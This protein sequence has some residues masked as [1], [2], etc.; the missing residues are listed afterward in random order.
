M[1]GRRDFLTVGLGTLA[2]ARAWGQDRPA[3]RPVKSV[4]WIWMDGGASQ[5]DTWDPKPGHPNSG[6]LHAID[7]VVP[8]IAI[9]ELMPRCAAQMDKLSILRTATTPAFFDDRSLD[10][11]GEAMHCSTPPG[12]EEVEPAT[13]TL[14]AFDLARF[15]PGPA[16]VAIDSPRIPEAKYFGAAH[17][18]FH[19]SP[20]DE[21]AWN[22]EGLRLP[23][24]AARALLAGQNQEWEQDRRVSTTDLYQQARIHSE[25]LGRKSF[26]EAFHTEGEPEALRREYGSGLGRRCLQARRL[27]EAG[28]AVV[29]VAQHGWEEGSRS[30][31]A[32]RRLAA[33]LDAALG[34]LVRDLA[35][36]DRLKD[37]VVICIGPAGRTPKLNFAGGR[38]SAYSTLSVVLAGGA[39]KGGRV[40]GDTGPGGIQPLPAVPYWNLHATIYRACGVDWNRKYSAPGHTKKYVSRGGSIATS[41]TPIAGFF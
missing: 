37:T 14:L 39:L 22:G 10:W 9:N 11:L 17:L 35:E 21:A 8:G 28:V 2:W 19:V 41:G 32:I 30:F 24:E 3:L 12:C 25:V 40:H 23:S 16:F 5:I 18:P 36:R 31:E 34:T 13:G 20:R 6:G 26:R 29:E 38:D 27:T 7:S 4:I 1:I 15:S 33:E